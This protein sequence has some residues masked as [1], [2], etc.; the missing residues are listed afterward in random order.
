MHRDTEVLMEKL[1]ALP[2]RR[3]TP[4]P[5][6]PFGARI[7]KAVTGDFYSCVLGF[8]FLYMVIH[9]LVVALP[10]W[11]VEQFY[12]CSLG[13]V[14]LTGFITDWIWKE[15]PPSRIARFFE[16]LTS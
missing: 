1:R 11:T 14:L 16:E 15:N 7:R 8:V 9:D 10:D 5:P 6:L 12:C 3:Y 13:V 4:P 2:V